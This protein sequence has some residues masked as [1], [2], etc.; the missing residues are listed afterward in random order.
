MTFLLD[1]SYLVNSQSDSGGTH[2][3]TNQAAATDNLP[4]KKKKKKRRSDSLT[5]GIIA[6]SSYG[7]NIRGAGV[8]TSTSTLIPKEYNTF[9]ERP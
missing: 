7:A 4:A 9:D 1:L 6:F 8:N 2:T 5:E 3:G